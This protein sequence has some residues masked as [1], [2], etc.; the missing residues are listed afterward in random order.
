M[1]NI[2]QDVIN[3]PFTS[4]T[5]EPT[6]IYQYTATEDMMFLAEIMDSTYYPV[7]LEVSQNDPQ[8]IVNQFYFEYQYSIGA[9]RDYVFMPT[10]TQWLFAVSTTNIPASGTISFQFTPATEAAIPFSLPPQSRTLL[11][12]FTAPIYSNMELTLYAA[13]TF[14]LEAEVVDK[15]GTVLGTNTYMSDPLTNA[16]WYFDDATFEPGGEYDIY[17]TNPADSGSE[18][19]GYFILRLYVSENDSAQFTLPA[20]NQPQT[21]YTRVSPSDEYI[22][23]VTLFDASGLPVILQINNGGIVLEHEFTTEGEQ[24]QPNQISYLKFNTETLFQLINNTSP[25]TAI[26]GQL[27]FLFTP[28]NNMK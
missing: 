7:A 3:I 11:T 17:I 22:T 24:W 27:D 13:S 18:V 14:T 1:K 12:S 21:V 9:G 16:T 6:L 8:G 20:D 2:K 4:S 25:L 26:S 5:T 10:G 15:A 28:Y 19:S 23:T